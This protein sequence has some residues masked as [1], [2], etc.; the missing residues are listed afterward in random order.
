MET[1]ITR[2]TLHA[3]VRTIVL[4]ALLLCPQ[5]LMPFGFFAHRHI[6]RLAVYT[7]PY[8]MM[9][10][11]REHVVFLSHRAV[12]PDR[13]AHA[14]HGEAQ[15]HYIDLDRYGDHPF[16]DLP[17]EWLQALSAFP[18][19]TLL[20]YG[21][22]PWHIQTMANR[23]RFAFQQ[24]NPDEILLQAAYLGHYVADACTPLHTTLDYNGREAHQKGIHGLW[25]SRL[26]ELLFDHYTFSVGKAEYVSDVLAKAWE[27]VKYSHTK[28]DALYHAFDSI[29]LNAPAHSI[30]S[31]QM[32]GQSHERVFS[33]QFCEDYHKALGGMVEAQM[34]LAIKTIGDL[35]Y[36]AWVDAGRPD[37]SV[38]ETRGLGNR[39]RRRLAREERQWEKQVGMSDS[40]I[41]R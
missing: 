36:S 33:L 23:L 24:G 9:G 6:N 39:L 18:E 19:D 12:D 10:F 1:K 15:R 17:M 20:Q 7:L 27:L 34:R 13:R 22:L 26:P 31:H 38:L 41:V 30:Y 29:Y 4:S 32:R 2:K 3:L 16:P 8:E 37:L 14:M 21:V 35:W 25:E 11:F 5:Y 40:L 28:L